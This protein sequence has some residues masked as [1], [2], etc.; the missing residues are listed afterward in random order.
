MDLLALL[1]ISVRNVKRNNW[2]TFLLIIGITLSIALETGITISVDSLYEN[3]I[4]DHRNNNYTDITI[5]SR[6]GSSLD[7]MNNQINAIKNTPGVLEA[8]VAATAILTENVLQAESELYY[9]TRS[10]I[11]YAFDPA[12]HPDF[13]ELDV[14]EGEKSLNYN[15]MI[16]SEG[17]AQA[18]MWNVKEFV[19]IG[20][21][22]EHNIK[23]SG[24][25]AN[26][27]FFGNKIGYYLVL[28]DINYLLDIG[29]TD[30]AWELFDFEISVKVDDILEIDAIADDLED[31]LGP[32]YVAYREKAITDLSKLGIQSYRSAMNIVLLVSFIVVIL[33]VTNVL[34]ISVN[35]RKKEFGILRSNGASNKQIIV[36]LSFEILI[37]SFIG[38]ILGNILGIVVSDVLLIFLNVTPS[39]SIGI[40]TVKPLTLVITFLSGILFSQ[41]AGI[42]PI[43]LALSLNPVQN[44]HSKQRSI[45]YRFSV[46]WKY[47]VV[48]GSILS[49]IGILG[50][51][52]IGPSQFLSFDVISTHFII[53]I[54]IITG[55]I[56]IEAGLLNF[57]PKIS[58]LLFWI[59][60]IPKIIASRQIRREYQKSLIT[61]ITTGIALSFII[62]IGLIA[63]GLISAVP[64][65]YEDQFGGIDII[66]ECMD[67]FELP[68][69]TADEITQ[70]R[71]IIR[72][73]Y[74]QEK[75]AHI[76]F[77]STEGFTLLGVEPTEFY[78]FMDRIL[79]SQDDNKNISELLEGNGAVITTLL[80][81]DLQVDVNDLLSVETYEGTYESVS[82]T[83][84]T[85]SNPFI[86]NGR[87]MFINTY[88]YRNMFNETIDPTAK[89]FVMATDPQEDASDLA[90]S[91]S[92][93][94]EEFNF[95]LNINY[96][97]DLIGDSIKVQAV[98]FQLLFLESFILAGL[99]QFVCILISTLQMER[100][101]GV[102]RSMGFSKSDVFSTFLVESTML[103]ITGVAFGIFDGIL[104]SW[105]IQWYIS[106]SIP[107]NIQIDFALIIFW[108]SVSLIITFVST[109]IPSYR[110]TT[111]S[112]VS[113]ISGRVFKEPEPVIEVIEEDK[114]EITFK[115][116]LLSRQVEIRNCVIVLLGIFVLVYLTNQNTIPFGAI[117][118]EWMFATP[119]SF[120]WFL[121]IP[122]TQYYIIGPSFV[123]LFFGIVMIGPIASYLLNRKLPFVDLYSLATSVL[124][125]AVTLVA[126][127]CIVLVI[128][129]SLVALYILIFS[130]STSAPVFFTGSSYASNILAPINIL[131]LLIT[132]YILTVYLQTL[133]I[134]Y[135]TGKTYNFYDLLFM[136]FQVNTN[137]DKTIYN[138]QLFLVVILVLQSYVLSVI[139]TVLFP[140]TDPTVLLLN[141]LGGVDPVRYLILSIYEIASIMLI[142]SYVVYTNYIKSY[143]EEEEDKKPKFF[144]SH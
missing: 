50:T 116:F 52:Y 139:M 5:H 127:L 41:V 25:M 98:L 119:N 35:E 27:E 24:I 22:F 108:V 126:L 82:I 121:L 28:V 43:L 86:R 15:E 21:I 6:T 97:S 134:Q 19:S 96:F 62:I 60:P 32:E 8:S 74:I 33:F 141:L 133:I 90:L 93:T 123:L 70:R 48:T 16:M 144:P 117:P 59:K 20:S 65:Y 73:T 115:N 113:A 91:I 76:P 109:S 80:A 61:I 66:A 79:Y 68:L 142:V 102:L 4:S 42:Y 128:I 49:F 46:T 12:T 92:H 131:I 36:S 31:K 83:G 101:M 95:V 39:V 17:L 71:E 9:Q 55:T 100:E 69:S 53:I 84:I 58:K 138:Q 34:A 57:L 135:K 10:V 63:G 103:G 120:F 89:W 94:Y 137:P 37:Y 29:L 143:E 78:Y 136:G 129:T 85:N 118:S 122:Y 13:K 140:V 14:I 104:G 30:Q 23:L 1:R 125:G 87:Y 45:K 99:A 132:S 105:L 107:I 64:T 111:Q 77:T 40:I 112:I 67:G 75:Y 7:T 3:F 2:R 51:Q 114:E 88:Y 44:I 106:L 26:N 130:S 81:Q 47:S 56:L 11:V 38:S 18:L 124:L 54:L 72:T 110:S